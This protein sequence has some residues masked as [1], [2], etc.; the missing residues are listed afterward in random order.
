[1]RPRKEQGEKTR[2][3]IIE[4]TAR[5]FEERGY[6]GTSLDV[7]AKEAE[8][9]KSSIFWH[10]DNKEDL[11]FTVVDQALSAWETR[12]GDAIL[13]E[14]SAKMRLTR[15]LE[16]HRLLA[17]EHP[18]TVRLLLGLLLE[19]SDA[20]E[21]L[22]LRF[23]RIYEGYHRSATS[24]IEAG[25]KDGSFRPVDSEAV[26]SVIQACFDGLFIQQFLWQRPMNDAQFALLKGM[27]F[28]QLTPGEK[29]D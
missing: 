14:T 9:S 4:V 23:Q 1:M 25:T 8:T 11:L 28:E 13:A 26:A 12:A 21:A 15:L 3:T 19:A 17:F 2:Q 16:M 10:F 24:I 29:S 27:V 20:V 5:L 22:R 7:V 6:A 18:S